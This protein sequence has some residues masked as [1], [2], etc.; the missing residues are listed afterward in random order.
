MNPSFHQSG[1]ASM[2]LESHVSALRTKHADL[3]RTLDHEQ[4]RPAPDSTAIKKLKVEK[5]RLKEEID[6]L[7][8]H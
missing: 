2:S 8:H 6:R 7:A 3:D 1:G 4:N 5:L